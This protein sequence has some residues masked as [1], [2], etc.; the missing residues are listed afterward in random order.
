MGFFSKPNVSRIEFDKHVMPHLAEHGVN[1]HERDRIRGMFEASL[2][3]H[4]TYKGIDKEE[5]HNTI[6]WMKDNMSK[7]N[8]PKAH[9]DL[10]EESLNAHMSH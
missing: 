3:G 8:I 2:D 7:H 5:M 1:Q 10:L 9:V 4:G 6:K